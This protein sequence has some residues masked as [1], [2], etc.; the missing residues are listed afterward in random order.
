MPTRWSSSPTTTSAVNENRRPPLTTFATRLISITRSFSSRDSATSAVLKTGVLPRVRPRRGPSRVRGRGSRPGRRRTPRSLPSSQR[1]R[2]PCRP[3]WPARSSCPCGRGS[4][5]SSQMRACGAP[6]RRRAGR[7]CRGSSG[8][9]RAAAARP[10]PP[11]CPAPAG[12]GGGAPRVARRSCPLPDLP[13]HLLALVADA[14]ALVRLGRAHLANLCSGL[15][16]DLLV[17]ALHDHLRRLG[18]VEG[19]P[20]ARRDRDRVREAHRELEVG[21]LELGAVAD[22]LD[23]EV[24]LEPLRDP[25]DHVRDER[26]G[27]AVE[28]AV[29]AALGGPGHRD[30]AVLLRDRHPC[31]DPLRER[32]ERARD[33][34]GAAGRHLDGDAARDLDGLSADPG[35]RY[36]TNAS[37]SPPTPRSAAWRVVITPIEVDR[38]AV[39][40]PP[41][42]RGRR[43]FLAYTR[44]PGLETR[45]RS[46]ITRSRFLPNLSS[47]TSELTGSASTTEK[48]L[49]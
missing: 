6:R 31:G 10:C 37:T 30:D 26:A 45:F 20:R 41:R 11:P 9:R 42:T 29:V 35:H 48:A 47:I 3:R 24:L 21:A 44:R 18:H 12:A 17:G 34:D 4:R 23:L 32:A 38:I 22:A 28:R 19:D 27:E 46:V 25:L 1:R 43:S 36:Q 5:A 14:L 39:P 40:S 15:T 8:R 16:D 49:I 2:A 33:R 13:A 7:R